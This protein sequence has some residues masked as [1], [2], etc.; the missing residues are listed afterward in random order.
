MSELGNL[1]TIAGIIAAFGI[2]MLY[3]R[4]QRELQ[5]DSSDE[6]IWI[7][8]AERLLIGATLLCLV[9][10]LLPVAS[11]LPLSGS[12]GRLP[13]AAATAALILVIGYVPAIFAHYRLLPGTRREGLYENPEPAESVITWSTVFL[14]GAGFLVVMMRLW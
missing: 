6:P 13:F 8:Y 14:A 1:S 4:I 12:L 7:P 9:L 5:M 11:Q 2:A 3:F 10:V